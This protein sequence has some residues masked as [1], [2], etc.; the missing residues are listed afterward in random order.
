[1]RENVFWLV[2]YRALVP[3]DTLIAD[4]AGGVRMCPE[5][6]LGYSKPRVGH[7]ELREALAPVLDLPVERVLVSHGE[8]VVAGGQVYVSTW[9]GRLYAFGLKK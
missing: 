4:D 3:G 5:S 9:G 6:W 1:M 2:G 8:P 7:A